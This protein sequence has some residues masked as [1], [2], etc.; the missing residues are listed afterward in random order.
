MAGQFERIE[1]FWKDY[2]YALR[3][4]PEI[5]DFGT[6]LDKE[7][8]NLI[9]SLQKAAIPW[10]K[11]RHSQIMNDIQQVPILDENLLNKYKETKN[12][13][14]S[15]K[16]TLPFIIDREAT[17]YFVEWFTKV[18]NDLNNIQQ[19][20]KSCQKQRQTISELVKNYF[21]ENDSEELDN[22]CQNVIQEYN[23]NTTRLTIPVNTFVNSLDYLKSVEKTNKIFAVLEKVKDTYSSIEVLS[24]HH[25]SFSTQIEA[26][27]ENE[28]IILNFN[29]STLNEKGIQYV[30]EKG[31]TQLK[32]EKQKQKEQEEAEAN[33]KKIAIKYEKKEKR[34]K[35]LLQEEQKNERV[36]AKTNA[37]KEY[38]ALATKLAEQITEIENSGMHPQRISE[39]LE[40]LYH[41]KE[42]YDKKLLQTLEIVDG[43]I[44]EIN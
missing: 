27:Y 44:K 36:N 4:D 39:I 16:K 17:P 38:T 11:L 18:D 43:S 5:K 24:F 19:Q 35:A 1:W 15:Y 9:D 28:K 32:R 6:W 7:L 25:P 31:M 37:I 10:R 41:A 3:E 29:L 8:I 12:K 22:T 42:V 23:S 14:F 21:E 13:F 33:R 34:R 2:N 40:P 20:L 30:H 26:I